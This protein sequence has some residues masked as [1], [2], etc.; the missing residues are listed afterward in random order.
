M[1]LFTPDIP[2]DSSL[3]S[4]GNLVTDFGE[5]RCVRQKSDFPDMDAQVDFFARYMVY[6]DVIEKHGPKVYGTDHIERCVYVEEIEGVTLDRYISRHINPW[7]AEGATA[8]DRVVNSA[9]NLIES[10][11]RDKFTSS[12]GSFGYIVEP[13][14]T[15]RQVDFSLIYY[16]GRERDDSAFEDY[17]NFKGVLEDALEDNVINRNNS[18]NLSD[19]DYQTQLGNIPGMVMTLMP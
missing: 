2:E 14:L 9:R 11:R 13:G 3:N 10:L 17:D 6:A 8:L 5:H 19:N 4:P 15:V 7:T 18:G 16:F 12:T 1:L